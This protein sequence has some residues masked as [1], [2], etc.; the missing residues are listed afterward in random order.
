[1]AFGAH[2]RVDQDLGDGV[3]RGRG[4]LA[5]VGGGKVPDVVHRVVVADVLQGV[6]DGL[7]EVFL[8]DR[9]AGDALALDWLTAGSLLAVG[10]V[11]GAF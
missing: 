9:R 1:V 11:T 6:G 10:K 2:A 4:L 7:D 8:L 3:L 5:L